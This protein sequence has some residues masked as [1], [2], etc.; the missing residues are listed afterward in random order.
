[1]A[2][3]NALTLR[4]IP[5]SPLHLVT[6]AVGDQKYLGKFVAKLGST[7]QSWLSAWTITFNVTTLLLEIFQLICTPPVLGIILVLP[8]LK[9]VMAAFQCK[10]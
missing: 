4:R 7:I 10:R 3:K 6:M 2:M 1:M 9:G 5:A 8:Q